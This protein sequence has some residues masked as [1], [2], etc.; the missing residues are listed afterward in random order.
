MPK[1]ITLKEAAAK[2]GL[3]YNCLRNLCLSGE[4]VHIRAGNKILVNEEKLIDYLNGEKRD[5][6]M[7][8]TT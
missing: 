2:S 5:A 8:K 4:L 1:M 7:D 6:R 3:S